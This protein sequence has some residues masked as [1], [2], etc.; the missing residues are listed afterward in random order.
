MALA[1][2]RFL[3]LSGCVCCRA[4]WLFYILHLELLQV[5]FIFKD[6]DFARRGAEV[7]PFGPDFSAFPYSSS[8]CP[9]T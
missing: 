9:Y 1:Q 4:P 7:F 3:I 2:E 5:Q 8:N 6:V